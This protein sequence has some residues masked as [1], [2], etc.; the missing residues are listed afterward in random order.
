MAGVDE[1]SNLRAIRKA[2]GLTQFQ[3]S[4][5]AKVSRFR[6]C[7]AESG[8][9]ELCAAEMEAIANAVR[10]EIEK[11]AQIA[12]ELTALVAQARLPGNRQPAEV[13]KTG[14]PR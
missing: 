7:M 11:T 8:S 13:E 1:V 2:A 3:L 14:G 6:L 10:P 9:L 12:A 4:Q 5:K